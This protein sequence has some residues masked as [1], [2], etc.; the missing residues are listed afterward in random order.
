MVMMAKTDVD[1]DTLKR[2]RTPSLDLRSRRLCRTTHTRAR[3]WPLLHCHNRAR[4]SACNT[5]ARWPFYY[6]LYF[7]IKRMRVTRPTPQC[8]L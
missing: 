3:T 5:V 8:R 6:F 2:I 7:P 4:V 1:K